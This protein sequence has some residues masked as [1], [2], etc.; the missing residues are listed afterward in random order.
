MKTRV[1][2]LGA[3]QK[4]DEPGTVLGVASVT[5]YSVYRIKKGQMFTI[6]SWARDVEKENVK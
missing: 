3:V 5:K 1:D 2:L 4:I 6:E